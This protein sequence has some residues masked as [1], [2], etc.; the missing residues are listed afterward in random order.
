[1]YDKPYS[2]DFFPILL[3]YDRNTER[4]YFLKIFKVHS[5]TKQKAAKQMLFAI[6]THRL[7]RGAPSKM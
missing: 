2:Y 3:M 4:Y 5:L 1:M 6:T 7:R